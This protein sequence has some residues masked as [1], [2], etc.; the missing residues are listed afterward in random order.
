[1]MLFMAVILSSAIF[2]LA[3]E[4]PTTLQVH[5]VQKGENLYQIA[6]AYGVSLQEVA[7]F[8]QLVDPSNIKVGQRILIPQS[9]IAQAI[10]HIVQPGETLKTIADRYSVSVAYLTELNQI[11]N[12]NQIY[13]GQEIMILDTVNTALSPTNNEAATVI[14]E[15]PMISES[16]IHVV[17]PG[18]TTFR[19]AEIY[20]SS[21]N[22]IA[23]ANHLADP[24]QIFVGQK[25]VIPDVK[26]PQQ[27]GDLPSPI[28]QFSIHPLI[29]I[30]GGTTSIHLSTSERAELSGTLIN[31]Y[32]NPISNAEGTEHAFMIGIPIFTEPGIY[33]LELQLTLTNGSQVSF[34]SYIQIVESHYGFQEI[35]I[36]DD[37]IELLSPVGDQ[38]ELG[39]LS[40]VTR[41]FTPVKY[42]TGPL[43]L[44]VAAAMNASFGA[45][46]S[47]NGGDYD[48][49]HSGADFA[50]APG[51]PV[52]AA[53][54]GVVV[55]KDKLNIRGYCT[56]IDHGWGVYSLYAH[57][58]EQY[59]NVGDIVQ[60]GQVIGTV[61]ASGRVTGAHLHW[62][63]WLNGVPVDPIDWLTNVYP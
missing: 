28:T 58:T 4:V 29:S 23:N 31:Q 13:P 16:I 33:P 40:D 30:E 9:T 27:T 35:E 12:A 2:V 6:Q 20:K 44:P 55:L 41:S 17:R 37:K 45:K 63:V 51:T 8:N 21:V 38:Y 48:R 56:I 52:Y 26:V 60:A 14:T 59:V 49:Y 10:V 43:G 7:T 19:I 46:R 3:Q 24:T 22:V 34:S 1:M 47:Y 57:Q 50:G 25:L 54:A 36:T 15:V 11:P 39:L 5:V 61:G 62:E 42:Y 53:A 18:E 32:L